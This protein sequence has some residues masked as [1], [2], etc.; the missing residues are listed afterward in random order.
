MY[1]RMTKRL[2]TQYSLIQKLTIKIKLSSIFLFVYFDR[3]WGGGDG[4]LEMFRT[5]VKS[6]SKDLGG[7]GHIKN[8]YCFHHPFG[9]KDFLVDRFPLTPLLIVVSYLQKLYSRLSMKNMIS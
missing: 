9:G 3:L 5:H 6:T 1:K 8:V 4:K 2:T 7:R